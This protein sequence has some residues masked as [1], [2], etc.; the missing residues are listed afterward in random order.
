MNI[1]VEAL[2]RE[3]GR[4]SIVNQMRK[5]GFI[6]AIL[7]GHSTEPLPIKLNKDYFL[8]IYRRTLGELAFFDLNIEGKV[9]K[10][11]MK[12]KQIHP[13]TREIEHIDFLEIR[14]DAKITVRIPFRI[15]GTPIGVSN[16]GGTLEVL[17]REVEASSFPKDLVEDI[18]VN[19]SDL[20]IGGVVTIGEVAIENI[21]FLVAE[22]LPIVI[23][24]PPKA[25]EEEVDEDALDGEEITEETEEEATE[26]E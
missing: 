17:L 16:N 18:E 14:Q 21:E 11:I 26:S 24:H 15:E 9:Y 2:K 19:V 7:Y 5:D 20:D 4:K 12:D 6:P 13:V 8:K 10:T 25:E 3:V 1:K 22:E 23:V